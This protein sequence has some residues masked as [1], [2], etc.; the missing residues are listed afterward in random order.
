[1]KESAAARSAKSLEQGLEACL[2]RLSGHFRGQGPTS[3]AEAEDLAQEVAL[4]ALRH[5]DSFDPQRALWP[6]LKRLA[7]N[8]RADHFRRAARE[9]QRLA[10][11]ELP[12]GVEAQTT[13][14]RVAHT[15]ALE[16]RDELTRALTRLSPLERDILLRFHERGDSI[17][18]ISQALGHPEGTIKSHLHRARRR[19]AEAESRA[20]AQERSSEER[21]H[22]DD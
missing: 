11:E 14:R 4:R 22:E 6:W 2:P 20:S 5:R 13:S 17:A 19:L 1:M 7:R 21:A 10:G 8:V 12:A 9:E 16:A 18:A 15:A 3:G